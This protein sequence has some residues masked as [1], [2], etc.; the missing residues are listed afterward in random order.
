M[1]DAP[2]LADLAGLLLI[3]LVAFALIKGLEVLFG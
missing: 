2:D 1:D 3:V